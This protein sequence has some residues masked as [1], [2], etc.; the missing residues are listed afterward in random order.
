MSRDPEDGKANDPKTLHKYLYSSG[1]PANRIDPTGRG[2]LVEAAL[3]F[4]VVQRIAF[5]LTCLGV[6]VMTLF[7]VVASHFPG[8]TFVNP[9]PWWIPAS[10]TAAGLLGL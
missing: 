2:D 1:D 3:A 6:K 7:L 10:C 5:R 9:M 8:S 4:V